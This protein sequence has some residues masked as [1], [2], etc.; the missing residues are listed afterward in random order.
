MVRYG[1]PGGGPVDIAL[2]AEWRQDPDLMVT[3]QD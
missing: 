3:G 1:R 2:C